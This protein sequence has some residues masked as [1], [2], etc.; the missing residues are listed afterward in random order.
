MQPERMSLLAPRRWA[1]LP[2]IQNS[3]RVVERS[4][5]VLLILG[6][7]QT[8]PRS[9]VL[10]IISS[11]ASAALASTVGLRLSLP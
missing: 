5:G 6:L 8:S 11:S 2:N 7:K 10:A 9:A 1:K 3:L 4:T